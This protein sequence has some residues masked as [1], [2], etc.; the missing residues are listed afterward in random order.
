[1]T[2]LPRSMTIHWVAPSLVSLRQDDSA[3]LSIALV[4]VSFP[5]LHSGFQPP[6][7]DMISAFQSSAVIRMGS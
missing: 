1:M 6:R 2:S 7:S 5:V 3:S 4:H